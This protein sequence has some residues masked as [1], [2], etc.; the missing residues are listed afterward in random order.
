MALKQVVW[1]VIP[2]AAACASPPAPRW[3]RSG[4]AES[5]VAEALQDCRAQAQARLS[6]T[7]SIAPGGPSASNTATE[8]DPVFVEHEADRCMQAKGFRQRR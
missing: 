2:L 8:R 1:L 6:P 5:A 4:A 3:E 7:P